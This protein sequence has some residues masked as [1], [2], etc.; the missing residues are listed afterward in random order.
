MISQIKRIIA[1]IYFILYTICCSKSLKLPF[2]KNKDSLFYNEWINMC[3]YFYKEIFNSDIYYNGKF[4]TSNKIDIVICNHISR[5]DSFLITSIIKN[6]T[7]KPIYPIIQKELK[8]IPLIGSFHKGCIVLERDLSKDKETIINSI[9]NI[10][11]GIIIIYPEGTRMNEDNFKKSH[12]YCE[13]NQLKKYNNLLYP[14]MKGLDIII[15][16]LNNSNKLGNLIDI[17]FRLKDSLKFKTG[18]LDFIKH[19]VGN[20][21]CNINSYKINKLCINNYD[22]LKNW[23]LMIWDKKEEY[24]NEY[25]NY[26]YKLIKNK[27]RTSTYI[28]ILTYFSF[29]IF[30]LKTFTNF[31]LFQKNNI[32]IN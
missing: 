27:Y 20:V 8:K 17:S 24:I 15:N 19:N 30:Y 31:S 32:V 11:N 9:K 23:I 4:L 22:N 1:F 5:I 2:I 10:D 18:Y 26:E 28:L 13:K 16:E 29:F 12:E 14:K 25:N 7:I 21:Y 6:N 3:P